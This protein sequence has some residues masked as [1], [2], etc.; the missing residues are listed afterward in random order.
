MGPRPN[1]LQGPEDQQRAPAGDH[2][3]VPGEDEHN[4]LASTSK[5]GAQYVHVYGKVPG[6]VE[7]VSRQPAHFPQP[8]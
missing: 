5:L 4:A 3:R 1:A 2:R 7:A 8:R 6:K